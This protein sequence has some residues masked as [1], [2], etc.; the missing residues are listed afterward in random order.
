MNTGL[1]WFAANAFTGLLL[2]A[3][4]AFGTAFGL[5]VSIGR[6]WA[7][8]LLAAAVGCLLPAVGGLLLPWEWGLGLAATA[9]LVLVGMVVVL[10][11]SSYWSSIT[12]WVCAA[13]IALGLRS[14]IAGPA[15]YGLEEFGRIATSISF[16]HPEWLSLLGLVPLV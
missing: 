13:L 9:L 5:R 11:S 1:A 7:W 6:Q 14:L 3:A 4:V 8:A 15:N 12:G 2:L 10:L 16:V